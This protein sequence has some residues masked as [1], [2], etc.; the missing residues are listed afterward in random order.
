[1]PKTL[2]QRVCKVLSLVATRMLVAP[3]HDKYL[4]HVSGW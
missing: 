2:K 4:D 1:M 3:P